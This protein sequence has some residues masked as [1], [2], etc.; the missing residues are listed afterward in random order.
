MAYF[1]TLF[2]DLKK[3]RDIKERNTFPSFIYYIQPLCSA[4]L[5]VFEI[6]YSL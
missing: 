3:I 2:T 1:T 6:G 5:I 4:T